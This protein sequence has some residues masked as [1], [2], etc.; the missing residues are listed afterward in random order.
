MPPRACARTHPPRVDWPEVDRRA[1]RTG[2]TGH[3]RDG[4]GR[5]GSRRDIEQPDRFVRRREAC[6]RSV[7]TPRRTGRKTRGG[8][9]LVGGCSRVPPRSWWGAA[10]EPPSERSRPALPR[11]RRAPP[12]CP[13]S[14]VDI[15]PLEAGRRAYRLYFDP[16]RGGCGSGSY[17]SLLSLL[18][19]KVGYPWTTLP[20]LMMSHAAAGY[21]GHGTL[22]G[23]LGGASCI[24][25]LVAYGHGEK[26]QIFRQM[27]D[28]LFYWYARPGVPDRPV[29]R[30]LRD[31][32]AGPREG[33]V[34]AVPHL[35]LEVG[36]GRR[37]R[38]LLQG[39]EGALR[40]GVRRGRL[41]RRARH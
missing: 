36:A 23:S 40:Q 11:P 30:H 19:E 12:P 29:R 41:H 33:D 4:P 37:G 7:M 8:L 9:V 1:G 14:G 16:V 6:I 35:G 31:A 39:E 17:L 24:I 21:G 26:G 13:G 5:S 28:R 25:N 2:E 22:C 38:D 10:W 3:C 34:A 15:D 32:R 27:I 18:K 20:D